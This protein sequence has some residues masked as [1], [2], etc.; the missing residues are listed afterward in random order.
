LLLPLK[1]DRNLKNLAQNK[2]ARNE[3]LIY[4]LEE[5]KENKASQLNIEQLK[6]HQ[7]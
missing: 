5:N 6:V 2:E 4:P 7:G 3:E 1:Y